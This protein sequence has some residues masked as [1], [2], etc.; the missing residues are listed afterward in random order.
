[1]CIHVGKL[2]E[3]FKATGQ[4]DPLLQH[5]LAYA[6]RIAMLLVGLIRLRVHTVAKLAKRFKKSRRRETSQSSW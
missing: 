3:A 1:L 6:T 5:Q 4:H 2:D